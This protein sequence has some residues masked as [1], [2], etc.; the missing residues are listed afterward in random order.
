MEKIASDNNIKNVDLIYIGQ[1][2]VSLSSTGVVTNN[3][4]FSNE[5]VTIMNGNKVTGTGTTIHT[6][7]NKCRLLQ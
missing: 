3:P 7:K 5:A 2:N 4:A 1:G 6:K